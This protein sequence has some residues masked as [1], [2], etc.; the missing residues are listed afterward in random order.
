MSMR[1]NWYRNFDK[2]EK[3]TFD[4]LAP[5]KPQ[6]RANNPKAIDAPVLFVEQVYAK[7]MAERGKTVDLENHESRPIERVDHLIGESKHV[8]FP[9][10][11]KISELKEVIS[12]DIRRSY[13]GKRRGKLKDFKNLSDKNIDDAVRRETRT[14]LD[15]FT[16]QVT[17]HY[18]KKNMHY[19]SGRGDGD[20]SYYI[21]YH[22]SLIHI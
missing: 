7:E 3:V 2:I 20:L 12:G 13:E 9:K 22:L 15:E 11:Y 5:N 19:L 8:N 1:G 14:I 16:A 21:K 17:K 6:N 18:D 4:E 10:E